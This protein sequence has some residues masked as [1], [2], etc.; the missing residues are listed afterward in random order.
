M[1]EDFAIAEKRFQNRTS[2][3]ALKKKQDIQR[4]LEERKIATATRMKHELHALERQQNTKSSIEIIDDCIY[5]AILEVRV[6][7]QLPKD[8]VQLPIA[9][10]ETLEGYRR[11]EVIY[12]LTFQI[13]ALNAGEPIIES[14]THC[15]VHEFT[16]PDGV[17]I[18]SSKVLTSLN[19]PSPPSYV[20]VSYFSLP[21]GTQATFA[22]ASL[23]ALDALT[24]R[25]DLKAFLQSSLHGYTCLT[26]GD[27]LMVP[28]AGL[29]EDVCLRV[30]A[31]LP[32]IT[33][34]QEKERR[35][36]ILIVNTDL[37]VEFQLDE[38]A[39]EHGGGISKS[40]I[41]QLGSNWSDLTDKFENEHVDTN[42]NERGGHFWLAKGQVRLPQIAVKMLESNAGNIVFE[43]DR[44]NTDA[45]K[46]NNGQVNSAAA[47]F[48]SSDKDIADIFLSFPPLSSATPHLYHV[49]SLTAPL[50]INH[51]S[52]AQQLVLSPQQIAKFLPSPPSLIHFSIQ[53]ISP[54]RPNLKIQVYSQVNSASPSSSPVA[55]P[56]T[57]S[58]VSIMQGDGVECPH[59]SQLLPKSSFDLHEL[60]CSRFYTKCQT[61]SV[62]LRKDLL[63][64]HTHCA[65]CGLSMSLKDIDRHNRIFHSSVNCSSCKMSCGDALE[66]QRHLEDTCPHRLVLCRFCGAYVVAGDDNDIDPVDRFNGLTPHEAYCGNKTTNCDKCSQTVRLKEISTHLAVRHGIY[67][68]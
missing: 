45:I 59:C 39:L 44:S 31:V 24:N 67:P 50:S 17:I 46:S 42:S 28:V 6:S 51:T 20:R 9:V 66:L 60:H 43:I 23:A 14:T 1:D 48:A 33:Y 18:L 58:N 65:T 10:L 36:G 68:D 38:A 62:V 54:T 4:L 32:S 2:A 52:R 7:D 56:P 35:E 8:K 55:P 29:S 25:P 3:A 41:V 37:T 64:N 34:L 63:I 19:Q 13:V 49:S 57:A 26:V 11:N 5:S 21:K 61:C 47:S 22:P 40:C 16:A 30:Q 53:I 15:G 27:Q 12:P